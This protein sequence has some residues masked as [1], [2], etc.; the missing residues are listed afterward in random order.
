MAYEELF[1]DLLKAERENPSPAQVSVQ[2]T[3]ANLGHPAPGM[4]N[5]TGVNVGDHY[6][7]HGLRIKNC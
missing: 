4:S 3:D 6:F 5:L 2:T 1:T 7:D